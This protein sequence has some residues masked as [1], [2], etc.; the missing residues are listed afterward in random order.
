MLR[1]KR[2]CGD[3][4][5]FIKRVNFHGTT[6]L[7]SGFLGRRDH[8]ALI[9]VFFC[10]HTTGVRFD[11]PSPLEE[12]CLSCMHAQLTAGVSYR[13]VGEKPHPS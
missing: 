7:H 5:G 4:V 6:S 11:A 8:I 9:L 12:T 3:C 10:N 2:R 13:S 1:F